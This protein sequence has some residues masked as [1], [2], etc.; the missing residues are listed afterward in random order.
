MKIS[1]LISLF[2]KYS[3]EVTLCAFDGVKNKY[4][5]RADLHAFILLDKLMPSKHDIICSAR[6]Q[7][8][9]LECEIEELS[10]VITEEQIKELVACGVSYDSSR[11]CLYMFT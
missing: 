2:D 1:E 4:S 3:E 9:F 8:I 10:K 5:N 6:H 7:E 11:C